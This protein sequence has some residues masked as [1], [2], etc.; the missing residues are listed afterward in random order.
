ME[1]GSKSRANEGSEVLKE[2]VSPAKT[3]AIALFV[4]LS[5]ILHLAIEAGRSRPVVYSSPKKICCFERTCQWL[6]ARFFLVELLLLFEK[7]P[8]PELYEKKWVHVAA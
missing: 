8:R 2:R 5:D 4:L 3:V 1:T 6:S 7:V